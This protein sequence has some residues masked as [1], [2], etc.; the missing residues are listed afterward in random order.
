MF[1]PGD[2]VF[3]KKAQTKSRKNSEGCEFK[4][5][6]FGIFLGHVPP[7]QKDPPIEHLMRIMG[8]A[9]FLTFDDVAEFLGNEQGSECV[10]KFEDKYYGKTVDVKIEPA[11]D[12][13]I[14]IPPEL[15]PPTPQL[16]G[17]DGKP[18]QK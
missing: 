1:K 13:Q 7:F 16:I 9:G 5:M 8:T 14:P 3:F 12:K 6:G 11:E 15:I 18:L 2:T 4:G 10:K 17:M